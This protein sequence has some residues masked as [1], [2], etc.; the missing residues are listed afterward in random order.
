MTSANIASQDQ[1]HPVA[2][3]LSRCTSLDKASPEEKAV[4]AHGQPF[5]GIVRPKGYR[6]RAI[7]QC[8]ANA[9]DLALQDFGTYVEGFAINSKTGALVHHGWL[10]LDGTNAVDVTWR[11]P[12]NECHYFGIPFSNKVLERFTL[13]TNTWGPLL[14]YDE[15]E[16][17]LR[18]AGLGPHSEVEQ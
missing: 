8:F 4:L 6:L 10:T 14:R 12:A 17:V 2:R 13:R 9:G 7:K 3:R 11:T 5:V 16:W 18:E 15:L 1:P